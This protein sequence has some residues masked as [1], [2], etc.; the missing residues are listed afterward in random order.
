L[1]ALAEQMKTEFSS[2]MHH[3]PSILVYEFGETEVMDDVCHVSVDIKLEYP[4]GKTKHKTQ[5]ML[6]AYEG[7]EHGIDYNTNDG[8]VGEINGA[9]IMTQ[10]YFS[11][12][13]WNIQA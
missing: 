7:G 5:F 12:I 3:L 10:L 13:D 11:K 6:T 9:N 8:D 2:A 1:K 4:E